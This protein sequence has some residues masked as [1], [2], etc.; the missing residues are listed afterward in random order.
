VNTGPAV[1]VAAR[2]TIGYAAGIIGVAG[3]AGVLQAVLTVLTAWV[4]R[5]LVLNRLA[6]ALI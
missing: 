1:G 5:F 3:R 2:L 4:K 6:R